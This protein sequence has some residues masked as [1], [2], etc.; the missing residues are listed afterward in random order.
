MGLSVPVTKRGCLFTKGCPVPNTARHQLFHGLPR[1]PRHPSEHA[2]LLTGQWPEADLRGGGR[3]A[4]TG[5]PADGQLQS[6]SWI[7]QQHLT[8]H[9]PWGGSRGCS[10]PGHQLSVSGEQLATGDLP[11]FRAMPSRIK[12]LFSPS[13]LCVC[14]VLSAFQIIPQFSSK[15]TF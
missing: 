14:A 8:C 11:E 7:G 6:S 5:S 13:H 9:G 3:R 2:F 12:Y 10:I 4:L 15:F 1:W